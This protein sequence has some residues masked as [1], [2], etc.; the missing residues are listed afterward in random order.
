MKRN[1]VVVND[2]KT[3]DRNNINDLE[4]PIVDNNNIAQQQG[5]IFKIRELQAITRGYNK[6]IRD[7]NNK[8]ARKDNERDDLIEDANDDTLKYKQRK[9]IVDKIRENELE[10]KKIK[11][12]ILEEQSEIDKVNVELDYQIE[13][14]NMQR[15]PPHVN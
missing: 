7:F 12:L 4:I 8:I 9:I 14:L 2:D 15:Y 11:D 13:R 5:I 3:Y 1:R 10:V 6:N